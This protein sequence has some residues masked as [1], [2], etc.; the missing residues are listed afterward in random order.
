MARVVAPAVV[1]AAL[2]AVLVVEGPGGVAGGEEVVVGALEDLGALE[3]EEVVAVE[4]AVEA[5]EDLGALEEEEVVAVEA[6]EVVAVEAEAEEVLQL[7]KRLTTGI[8]ALRR[9]QLP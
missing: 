5:L 7:P 9:S 1:V 4:V 3:E 8:T 6:L 2:E